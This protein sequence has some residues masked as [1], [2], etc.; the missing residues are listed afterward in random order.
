MTY[1]HPPC[2][3]MRRVLDVCLCSTRHA[4]KGVCANHHY[5]GLDFSGDGEVGNR[6]FMGIVIGTQEGVNSTAK[7]LGP[8]QIHMRTIKDKATKNMIFSK[9]RFDNSVTMALC[10][11]LDKDCVIKRVRLQKNIGHHHPAI[12]IVRAY[13]Y[14]LYRHIQKIIAAFLAKH[15]YVAQDATFQCDSDCRDFVKS[16]GLKHDEPGEAHM[17]A[18]IVA[19]SK[20]NGREPE[21]VR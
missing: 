8:R 21:E 14:I 10:I 5:V 20:N 9:L 7:N 1:S 2:L 19:W 13:D 16:N 11:R 12:R 3:K 18:D 6:K 4:D 15:G 17:L